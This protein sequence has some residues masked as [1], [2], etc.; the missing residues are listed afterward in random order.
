MKSLS[1]DD[2]VKY[3]LE[4]KGAAFGFIPNSRNGKT[5]GGQIFVIEY[6]EDHASDPDEYPE[7][8][9]H[10]TAGLF[11]SSEGEE[12]SYWPDDAPDEAKGITYQ[13]TKCDV[14]DLGLEIQ[15]LLDKLNATAL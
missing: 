8:F 12:E 1:F 5:I 13:P 4:S 3:I 15:L 14:S 11:R 9:V 2:A 7:Y 10:Y 6:C